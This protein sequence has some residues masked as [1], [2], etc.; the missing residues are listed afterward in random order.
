[1]TPRSLEFLND[2]NND[3]EEVYKQK[4]TTNE[5]YNALDVLRRGVSYCAEN[6]DLHYKYGNFIKSL[7][8]KNQ[9]QQTIDQYLKRSEFVFNNL[10]KF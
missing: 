2:D 9:K 4:P 7:I 1:M 5:M 6:F 10:V 8:E 3:C